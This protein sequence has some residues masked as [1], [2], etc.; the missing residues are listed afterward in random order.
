VNTVS[1]R[2]VEKLPEPLFSRLRGSVFADVQQ[3]SAELASAL[4]QEASTALSSRMFLPSAY[5][6]GAF[7]GEELVGWS[8]GW[9]EPPSETMRSPTTLWAIRSQHSAVNNP[10]II[11]K[12]RAGFHVSGL[13]QS[14]QMGSLVEMTLHLSEQRYALF[15]RRALP[16]AVPDA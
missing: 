12:L 9:I 16:Y 10:V 5:R 1:I 2:P 8:A 6:F 13:S 3:P 7:D 11:A 4:A 15:R 14:A